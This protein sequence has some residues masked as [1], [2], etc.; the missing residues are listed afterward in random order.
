[1]AQEERKENF[2]GFQVFNFAL[3]PKSKHGNL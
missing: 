2:R 1:M 3:F